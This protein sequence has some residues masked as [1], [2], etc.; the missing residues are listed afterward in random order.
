MRILFCLLLAT[1]GVAVIGNLIA[2]NGATL[3]WTP[4]A[5]FTFGEVVGA[6]MGVLAWNTVVPH[7]KNE[8]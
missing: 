3:Q 1:V 4:Y 8:G 5:E 2:I 7:A 6:V